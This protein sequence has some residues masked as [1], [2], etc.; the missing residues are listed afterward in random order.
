MIN[1]KFLIPFKIRQTNFKQFL[2]PGSMVFL[3]K[4]I[5]KHT[6]DITFTRN[7]FPTESASSLVV[8]DQRGYGKVCVNDI[9]NASFISNML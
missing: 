5:L 9:S 8:K 3:Y 7:G 2:L 4:F 6:F 1:A